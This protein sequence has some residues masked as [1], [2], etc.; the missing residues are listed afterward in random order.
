MRVMAG[1]TVGDSGQGSSRDRGW[2]CKGSQAEGPPHET[3]SR[4]GS[5]AAKAWQRRGRGS[6]NMPGQ[7][8]RA[9]GGGEVKEHKEFI[10]L[11]WEAQGTTGRSCGWWKQPGVDSGPAMKAELQVADG[12][13]VAGAV[14]GGELQGM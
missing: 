2:L 13:L 4:A 5:A 10:S 3:S 6:E 12:D 9:W 8:T 7:V 11:Q 1:V 14:K